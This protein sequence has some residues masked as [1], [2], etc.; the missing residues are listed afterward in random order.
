MSQSMDSVSQIRNKRMKPQNH[1][2]IFGFDSAWTDNPKAP[3]AICAIT[4]DAHGKAGFHAPFLASFAKAYEFI[5]QQGQSYPLRLIALDQP[6]IVNNLSGSR[7]VDKVAASLVSF[8]GGGVQPANRSK[9]GMFDDAAA[10][11]PFLTRLQAQQNPLKAQEA[12]SGTFLIE[13]FPALA[14]LALNDEFSQRKGAPKYNP[15]NRKRFRHEDWH[16]VTQTVKRVAE[17][18]GVTELADWA[19]QMS[20]LDAPHKS[21]QDKLDAAICAVVGLIWRAGAKDASAMFGDLET[22]YMVTPLSN[23]TRPRLM[24]AASVRD[25]CMS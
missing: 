24:Q 21:D 14:L 11:W 4:F 8:A 7:P 20:A 12:Q 5:T 18:F 19:A 16:A 13:V 23:A 17:D 2:I 9:V 1:S 22:G 10:I 25:V 15:A 3:G 6:T